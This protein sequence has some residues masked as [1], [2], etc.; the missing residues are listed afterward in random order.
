MPKTLRELMFSPSCHNPLGFAIHIKNIHIK[1][2]KKLHQGESRLAGKGK[3]LGLFLGE[4]R[5]WRERIGHCWFSSLFQ[6][7]NIKF[8]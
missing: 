8:S 1:K 7:G 4:K 2:K 5:W 6:K 3:I